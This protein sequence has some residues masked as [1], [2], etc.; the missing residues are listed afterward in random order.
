MKKLR[1]IL[2][3][4]VFVIGQISAQQTD[5]QKKEE[6]TTADL[7]A[8]M[9]M[10]QD[11]DLGK[12]VQNLSQQMSQLGISES[13]DMNQLMALYQ[14]LGLS[15]AETTNLKAALELGKMEAE[16]GGSLFELQRAMNTDGKLQRKGEL[17]ENMSDEDFDTYAKLAAFNYAFEGDPNST[18]AS[19][20]QALDDFVAGMNLTGE[21]KDVFYKIMESHRSGQPITDPN[22]FKLE[23]DNGNEIGL[24]DF[25][26]ETATETIQGVNAAFSEMKSKYK[27]MSYADFK[28]EMMSDPLLKSQGITEAQVQELYNE[29]QANGGDLFKAIEKYEARHK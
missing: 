15:E 14:Q 1:L 25:M 17:F 19:R 26:S 21:Q 10:L 7:N 29:L 11:E 28:E 16:E 5:K 20:K 23:D 6:N 22:M 13:M 9:E 8:V 4:F 2:V 3:L 12:A 27:N 18:E 24:G